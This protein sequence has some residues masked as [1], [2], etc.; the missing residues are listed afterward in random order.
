MSAAYRIVLTGGQEAPV[1]VV[2]SATGSGYAIFDSV[3]SALSYSMNI[4][5]LDF[6][7]WLALAAQTVTPLDNVIAA[8]FH[9]GASGVAG[10]PIFDLMLADDDFSGTIN[11]NGTSTLS[12]NWETTDLTSLTPHLATFSGAGALGSEIPIYINLHTSANTGGEIRGQLIL[13]AT[14]AS[15]TVTGTSGV[16][17]LP[18]LGGNDVING[19][20][21]NDTL[22]GGAGADTLDGGAGVDTMRGGSGNDTYVVD[23]AGDLTIEGAGASG[24][25]LVLSS[26]TRSLGAN[27]EKLKLSGATAI[28]G[29]G[30]TLANVLTGNSLANTLSGLSGAD[31]LIGGGGADRLYG[32]GGLDTLTGGNGADK[33]VF[34]IAPTAASQDNITDFNAA[35]DTIQIASAAFAGIGGPG[36]LLADAFHLGG[37]AADANDRIIYDQAS[38]TLWFDADGF[39]GAAQI[40]FAT[41]TNNAALT[42]ADFVVI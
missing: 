9:P 29:T 37:S 19:L 16:D 4:S 38:G 42:A 8:H 20:G 34:N 30:N 17:F 40:Q 3:T 26:V 27:L 2:T 12:G 15:E 6:G 36:V 31:K 35:A 39:G 24:I 22:E 28:N 13:I 41:L 18:G 32:G 5:G 1:P 7:P 33:F 25:D 10:G 21:S 23:S 11:P 14:D